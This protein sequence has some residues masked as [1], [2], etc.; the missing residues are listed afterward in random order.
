MIYVFLIILKKEIKT[1]VGKKTRKKIKSAESDT[2]VA[3]G[4]GMHNKI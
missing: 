3:G 1:A 2:P 4:C